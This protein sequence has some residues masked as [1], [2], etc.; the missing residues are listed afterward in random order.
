[1]VTLPSILSSFL[2]GKSNKWLTPNTEDALAELLCRRFFVPDS[3]AFRESMSGALLELTYAWNWEQY[4][5]MTPT[6]A[7]AAF[8]DIYNQ[9]ALESAC[10]VLVPAPYWDDDN[11]DDT[12]IELPADEQD[13]W[14]ELVDGLFQTRIE[15]WIVA[16]GFLAVTGSPSAAVKFLVAAPKF[17]LL[18]QAGEWGRIIKILIDGVEYVSELDTY[19]PV[20]AV[21]SV[22]V[23]VPPSMLFA[24]SDASDTHELIIAATDAHNEAAVPID[25]EFQM[26]IIRK[27]L[28]ESEVGVST[29]LRQN[30]ENSCQMQ[31]SIDDGDTWSLAYDFSLCVPNFGETLINIGTGNTVIINP[32]APT[33][34]FTSQ[35]G[36]TDEQ[37]QARVDGLC[38]AS[39][40]IVAGMMQAAF[41]ACDGTATGLNLGG[42]VLGIITIVLVG[43]EIVSA[44]SL[45]ALLMAAFAALLEIAGQVQAL[46]CNAYLD[47]DT[48][49]IMT[50]LVFQNLMNK[51][52]TLANFRQAFS[53][54][55]C[56]T[57]DAH[58]VASVLNSMLQ[59]PSQGQAL[60]DNFLN[61]LAGAQ[62]AALQG[63][64]LPSCICDDETWCYMANFQTGQQDWIAIAAP[65][66]G[67]AAIYVAGCG[68]RSLPYEGTVATASWVNQWDCS[69]ALSAGLNI[70]R[71]FYV[72]NGCV[73][74]EATLRFNSVAGGVGLE[75]QRVLI[76]GS[77]C[78]VNDLTP[79]GG[80]FDFVVEMGGL[81]EG[82]HTLNFGAADNGG[83][84]QL[85]IYALELRGTGVS[86]FGYCNNCD[87]PDPCS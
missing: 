38:Y 63:A 50:C 57:G 79:G 2:V 74:T 67:I 52:V 85:D 81:T 68:F 25:G 19:S 84:A 45:T 36:D 82:T 70:E 44:G 14:G 17:R 56:L 5:T 18:I 41:F 23:I 37:K 1:V 9:Y 65:E 15:D 72:P 60:F 51:G 64:T 20:D 47:P 29:I 35:P 83:G 59:S 77:A 48:A 22:D 87:P 3:D 58:D 53:N 66:Q 46:D 24:V 40:T 32:A 39:Q 7:A 26:R 12:D 42:L 8:L 55:E 30:P 10:E 86:L 75:G 78:F 80:H 69:S 27:Q 49:N 11:G 34:T 28:T 33:E 76:D 62:S 31:Y 71:E 13:W 61:A 73:V 6:E 16:A 43:V 54:F 4:G 21:L